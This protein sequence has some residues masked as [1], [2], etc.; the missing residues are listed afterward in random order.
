MKLEHGRHNK[1]VCDNL[2]LQDKYEC[3]DWVVT[4]SFYSAIHFIDHALFPCQHNGKTFKDIN[5]AHRE[6]NARSKHATREILV[7][8]YLPK[9]KAEYSFLLSESQTARYVNYD[10]NQAFADK[11][12]RHL[13]AIQKAFDKEKKDIK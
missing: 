9:F 13:N 10:L 1:V 3:K 7:N 11:A 12:V 5:E 4:T 6:L 2:Y 8:K